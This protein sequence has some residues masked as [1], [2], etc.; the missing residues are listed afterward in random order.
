MEQ[1]SIQ[2][3]FGAKAG[4]RVSCWLPA[5]GGAAVPASTAL[6]GKGG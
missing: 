2:L 5:P 4:P 6:L 3:A 1:M